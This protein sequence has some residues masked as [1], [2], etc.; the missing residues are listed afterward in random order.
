MNI[1]ARSHT[2]YVLSQN[3]SK[4]ALRAVKYTLRKRRAHHDAPEVDSRLEYSVIYYEKQHANDGLDRFGSR[5]FDVHGTLRSAAASIAINSCRDE[6][7]TLT[8]L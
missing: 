7:I 1:R 6:L 8:G 2:H 3:F 4:A 5:R